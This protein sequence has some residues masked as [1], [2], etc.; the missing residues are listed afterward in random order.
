[1]LENEGGIRLVVKGRVFRCA[2]LDEE[3]KIKLVS[4]V[5]ADRI[6]GKDRRKMYQDKEFGK[7]SKWWM[8]INS[9]KNGWGPRK[10]NKVERG[11]NIEHRR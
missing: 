10:E 5:I 3:R 4:V 9:R 6:R 7:E 1:M 2:S 8:K 11:V